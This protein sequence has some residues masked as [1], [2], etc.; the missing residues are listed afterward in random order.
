[1]FVEI[2][3]KKYLDIIFIK[4]EVVLKAFKKDLIYILRFFKK[5]SL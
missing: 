3:I 5:N 4:K 2:G 1:M